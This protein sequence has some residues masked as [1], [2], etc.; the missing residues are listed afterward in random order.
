MRH[1]GL[2]RA[3]GW[4]ARQSRVADDVAIAATILSL[5][6][7][8]SFLLASRESQQVL[9]AL[10]RSTR[11]LSDDAPVDEIAAYVQ[12]LPAAALPGLARNVK[13]IAHEIAFVDAENADGDAITAE[14]YPAVNHPASDVVLH[15]HATGLE[16]A[17]QLKATDSRGYA[18]AALEAHPGIPVYATDEAADADRGVL[19]SGLSNGDLE[20]QVSAVLSA[21]DGGLESIFCGALTAG[22]LVTALRG[23]RLLARTSNERCVSGGEWSD[24]GRDAARSGIRAAVI[25][26]LGM[27]P[28]G[29]LVGFY[30]TGRL[31]TA[32]VRS[33]GRSG[34]LGLLSTRLRML[35]SRHAEVTA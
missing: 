19:A 27:T 1:P 32:L 5:R 9:E 16:Q 15:D 7:G 23:V 4:I 6:L 26:G 22:L 31:A 18:S 25:A 14:L 30:L 28:A 2:P 29:P 33:L 34:A 10:R 13:G 24:V 11:Q 8:S 12:S 21:L 20:A 3:Q 17:V 35:L